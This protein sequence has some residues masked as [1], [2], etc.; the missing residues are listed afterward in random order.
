MSLLSLVKSCIVNFILLW[1][2][3]QYIY[4]F[5]LLLPISSYSDEKT[6]V[7]SSSVLFT[8]ICVCVHKAHVC[9]C[10]VCFSLGKRVIF[11]TL[12]I[13]CFP[14]G[15][16]CYTFLL[17]NYFWATESGRPPWKAFEDN[18]SVWTPAIYSIWKQ[19]R[20]KADW[21][22]FPECLKV[23]ER[24]IKI[25]TKSF[26]GAC[27]ENTKVSPSFIWHILRPTWVCLLIL[28]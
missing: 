11:L 19:R 12:N 7:S 5:F 6:H 8:W 17:L 25:Q 13:Q 21:D 22:Y 28:C 14:L 15:L 18:Y 2:A 3:E 20:S 1:K 24:T 9:V 26:I 10:I 4:I 27:L 16:I 23:L